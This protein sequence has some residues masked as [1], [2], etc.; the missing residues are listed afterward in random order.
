MIAVLMMATILAACG[1]APATTGGGTPEAGAKAFVEALYGGDAA[2]TRASIC[3]AAV[4]TMTDEATAA[5]NSAMGGAELDLS[6]VT[7]AASDVTDTTATVTLS[8]AMKLTI[9]GTTS[10]VPMAQS[11]FGSLKMLKEGGAWKACPTM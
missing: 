3:A 5:I 10:E 7:Y 2:A 8:G 9:A 4:A 1:G 11:G 6:G